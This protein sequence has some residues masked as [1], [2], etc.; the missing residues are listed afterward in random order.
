MGKQ[1]E[2]IINI[3]SYI[4]ILWLVAY[5]TNHNNKDRN[6]KIEFHMQQGIRLTILGLV[7]WVALMILGPALGLLGFIGN[8]IYNIIVV[9]RNVIVIGLMIYGIIN[10]ATD[11]EIKLPIIG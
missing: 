1:E 7:L 3:L 9:F 6:E 2:K 10:A 5:V 4:G 8:F 11:K